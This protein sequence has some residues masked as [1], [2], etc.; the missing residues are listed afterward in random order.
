M[1]TPIPKLLMDSNT[2]ATEKTDKTTTLAKKLAE[3]IIK[4]TLN[5]TTPTIKLAQMQ[6][7]I[8]KETK[9]TI[10]KE[11]TIPEDLPVKKQ[12]GKKKLNVTKDIRNAASC[13]AAT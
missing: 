11:V 5:T 8:D 3:T 9:F 6:E 10:Q 1:E 13:Y 7:N 12:I 4:Q 2:N